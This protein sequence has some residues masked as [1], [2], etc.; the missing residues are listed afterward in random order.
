M[1]SS[2]SWVGP[3]MGRLV[4]ANSPPFGL[5][6]VQTLGGVYSGELLIPT[7]PGLSTAEGSREA[8]PST[9]VG[10]ESRIVE[11]EPAP[12]PGAHS[13]LGP[14]GTMRDGFRALIE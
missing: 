5:F 14:S 7:A 8:R 1:G 11:S 4:L 10:F 3:A 12:Q 2:L 9:Y 6:Q 13:S